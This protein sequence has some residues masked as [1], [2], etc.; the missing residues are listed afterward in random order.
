M[1]TAGAQLLTRENNPAVS[2][3]EFI[4][5]KLRFSCSCERVDDRFCPTFRPAV[6][7]SRRCLQQRWR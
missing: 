7:A 4:R 6:Q 2:L 5:S 3:N 1:L